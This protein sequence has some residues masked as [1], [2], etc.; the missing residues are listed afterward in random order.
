MPPQVCMG[1]YA[2]Q[3]MKAVRNSPEGRGPPLTCVFALSWV[4]ERWLPNDESGLPLT[5]PRPPPETASIE[6]C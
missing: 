2:S 6:K 5:R 1:A 4:V 3:P